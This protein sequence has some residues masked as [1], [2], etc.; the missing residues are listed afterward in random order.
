MSAGKALRRGRLASARFLP[1]VLLVFAACGRGGEAPAERH[2]VIS[3]GPQITETIF[4][5]GEGRR[6]IAVSDFCD[7]PPEVEK[8]P[9]VGGYM[10]PDFEKITLLRPEMVFLSGKHL[11]MT[12]FCEQSGIP[13]VNVY[14]DSLGT[15][16]EGIKT[17]GDALGVPE[18]ATELRRRVREELEAVR[19][20]VAGKP[21][22]K[23]LIL[24]GRT[25][26]NLNNLPTVGGG[27]FVSE[28][29]ELAGGENLYEEADRPYLEASKETAVL[30]APDVVLEFHAGENLDDEEKRA[31]VAD[32]AQLASIP[33]VRDGRIYILTES[34]ALRPGPR[35]PE[36]ARKIAG[37]LHPS[38]EPDRP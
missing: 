30:K 14:M 33:A 9:R 15:I 7:Y 16:D 37:L 4:A 6:L 13:H 38:P 2:G 22:P 18:K 32:W 31:Y 29:V 35:L 36:I 26:H 5:L 3:M 10:N 28:L 34:H 24:T 17:I 11:E 12:R 8:L 23:V 27:S 21:R 20:S 25:E 19:A 1:L